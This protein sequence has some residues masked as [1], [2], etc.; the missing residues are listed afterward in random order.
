MELAFRETLRAAYY[1]RQ[2]AQKGNPLSAVAYGVSLFLGIS[3]EQNKSLAVTYFRSADRENAEGQCHYG[4]C[5]VTG[6]GVMANEELG[7]NLFTLSADQGFRQAQYCFAV[8]LASGT[9]VHKHPPLAAHFFFG[10]CVTRG[11]SM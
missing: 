5:L 6:N 7:A 4:F 3:K 9:G 8:C 11:D 1:F 10:V 2:S